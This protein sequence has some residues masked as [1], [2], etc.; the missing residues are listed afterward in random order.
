KEQ[1]TLGSKESKLELYNEDGKI[2]AEK[3][4]RDGKPN[5]T[6]YYYQKDGKTLTSKEM[7]ENG[8]LHGV[9]TMYHDNGEK[10]V[11]ETWKFNLITGPV[12]NYYEDG[13]LLSECLYRGSRQHGLYTS[14]YANGKIK[15]Q[16]TYVA[17]KK[18]KE[19]KEFDETG[20][21][22]KTLVFQGGILISEK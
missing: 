22:L 16:G 14:Y 15:E 19:W 10:S 21:L 13:K 18:H 2:T 9:R 8:M 6:W 4:F 20:K 12:K 17:N 7:Y 3:N 1:F 5:G 11:E